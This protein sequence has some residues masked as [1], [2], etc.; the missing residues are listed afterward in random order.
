MALPLLR[1]LVQAGR[2]Q[3]VAKAERAACGLAGLG[4]GLTPSGDDTLGGFIG[5]LALA[6]AQTGTD[7]TANKRLTEGIASAARP[8]TTLLSATLLAHAARGEMAEQVGELLMALTLPQEADA[9]VLQAAEGVL[10]FGACSGGDTLLGLLLG[11]Q[12]IGSNYPIDD[13]GVHYGDT[14]ATQTQY[15]L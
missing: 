11:L 6:D 14:G 1:L 8:H 15:V 7:T 10:A 5:V 12:T 3:D 9:A 13:T 4:P 2:E